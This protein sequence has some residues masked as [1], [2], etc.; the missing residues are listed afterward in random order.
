[1]LH[2]FASGGKLLIDCQPSELT[3]VTS[4]ALPDVFT[5]LSSRLL[6]ASLGKQK[7]PD[8]GESGF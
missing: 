3:V 8:S 1:M 4:A 2:S 6:P 7:K 5:V